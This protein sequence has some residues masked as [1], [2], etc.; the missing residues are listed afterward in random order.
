M[1]SVVLWPLL[2]LGASAIA[3]APTMESAGQRSLVYWLVTPALLAG[4]LAA[5]SRLGAW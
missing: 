4:A 1:H 5:C 2:I 3:F